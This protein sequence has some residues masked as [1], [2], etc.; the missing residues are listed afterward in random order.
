MKILKNKMSNSS[1]GSGGRA[2]VI[3]MFPVM[4]VAF[5]TSLAG[6]IAAKAGAARGL[7]RFILFPTTFA[8]SNF[9]GLL[10]FSSVNFTY[11]LLR[12]SPDH[13]LYSKLTD[14]LDLTFFNVWGRFMGWFY[15][16]NVPASA[17]DLQV[18]V[19]HVIIF[20]VVVWLFIGNVFARFWTNCIMS[21]AGR[22]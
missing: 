16:F 12:G 20:Q 14:Y 2:A 6:F 5:V 17:Y 3:L 9:F 1:V 22:E 11:A 19:W 10:I 7:V 18:P 4:L 21:L 13:L 8:C 15:D